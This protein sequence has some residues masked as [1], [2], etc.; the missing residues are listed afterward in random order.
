[1]KRTATLNASN[2]RSLT[3]IGAG[4]MGGGM[5]ANLLGQ[6]WRVEVRD[7]DPAKVADLGFFGVRAQIFSAK[8]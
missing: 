4:N 8:G 5:A 6:G 2:S 1:V 7:I 3:L